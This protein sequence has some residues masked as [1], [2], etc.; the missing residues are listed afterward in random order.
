MACLETYLDTVSSLDLEH[1]AN[2]RIEIHINTKE[3]PKVSVIIPLF[4]LKEYVG[5]AIDCVL[6][7]TYPNIE[8]IVIDDGSTDQPQT[9]LNE[10][11]DHIRLITQENRG[12]SSARNTGIKNSRGEYLVFLD[13]DDGIFPDKIETEV[14]TLEKYP[15]IGWVY[16]S[17]LIIDKN[18]QIIGRLPDENIKSSGRPP[19]GKIFDTLISIN[20]MPVNAVMIRRKVLD[21]GLFD[22][23]LRSYEDLDFWLRVSAKYE[24]KYINKPLSFVRFRRD[25]MQ[26]NTIRFCSNRI[27]QINKACRLYPDLTRPHRRQISRV[28]AEVHNNLGLE[29]YHRHRFVESAHEFLIAVRT[30]PFQRMAY[31]YL[32]LLLLRHLCKLLKR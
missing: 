24:V 23:S 1:V 5:E 26:R 13:A 3:K 32:T 15:E 19:E 27:R 14:R 21:V 11:K 16:G 29:Y 10:Y 9:V 28:L 17:V 30:C 2:R 6:N 4:N 8:I 18:K 12:L 31:S 25:S 20:I 22:E 7:Q